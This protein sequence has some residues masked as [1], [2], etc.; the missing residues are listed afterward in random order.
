MVSQAADVDEHHVD[1][2]LA[3]ALLDGEPWQLGRDALSLSRAQGDDA[4]EPHDQADQRPDDDPTDAMDRGVALGDL[5]RQPAQ[6]EDEHHDRDRLDEGLGQREVGSAVQGE[7]RDEPEAGHADEQHGGHALLRP[8]GRDR[9]DRHDER[10][11]H[12][13][14]IVPQPDLARPGAPEEGDRA[15]GQDEDHEDGATGTGRARR[16]GRTGDASRRAGRCRCTPPSSPS[17][18]R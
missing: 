9:R 12:L 18:S 10:D 1:D 14:G 5:G 6:H 11:G 17:R 2:V 13:S 4:D 15:E 8:G 7:Q 3:V 16:A